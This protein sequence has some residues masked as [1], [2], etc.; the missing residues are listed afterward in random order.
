MAGKAYL[1]SNCSL[2]G[3]SSLIYTS[4]QTEYY[5][6]PKFYYTKRIIIF[7]IALE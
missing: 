5:I 2:I 7:G 6:Y 4:L 3:S 1:D